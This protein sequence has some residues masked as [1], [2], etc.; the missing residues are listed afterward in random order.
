MKKIGCCCLE[1]FT[2]EYCHIVNEN[3][4]FKNEKF[5]LPFTC[6]LVVLVVSL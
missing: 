2:L 5:Y 3:L 4:H 1:M 6:L